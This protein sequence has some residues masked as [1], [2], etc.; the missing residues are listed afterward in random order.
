MGTAI[1]TLRHNEYY[2]LQKTFDKLYSL[3]KNGSKFKNL[4]PLL[5]SENNIMLAYRNI[6]SNSGSKTA[7]TDNKTIQDIEKLNKQILI[8]R[9]KNKLS[10]YKP[11]K[12]RRVYI[13]KKN[14]KLRP[15]GIPNIEDRIIQQCMKQ[16]LE[17]ISEAK[18][19]QHSYGFRPNRGTHNAMARCMHLVNQN[20]LTYVVDIDIKGFF[21]NVNHNI[22]IK[23]LWNMGIRDKRILCIIKKM[24]KAEIEG[25]G[26]PEKGT[27]QG[28]ILSPLLANIYLN[29]LDW[30]IASQWE[31]FPAKTQKEIK[32]QCNKNQ[33]YSN[34]SK[35]YRALRKSNLKEMFIVRYA[36]DFKIFCRNNKQAKKIYYGINKWL[37]EN[38]KLDISP[39]K[40]KIINLVERKS[41][42]LGFEMKAYE[43]KN[44][45]RG[46]YILRTYISNESLIKIKT[47]LFEYIKKIQKHPIQYQV[48]QLNAYIIGIH[49]YYE[50]AS[51]VYLD[52]NKI[53]IYY[54]KMIQRRLRNHISKEGF[55][56]QLYL[57]R[58]E[59]MKGYKVA[60]CN[61]QI[62]P[63]L[64]VKNKPPMNF[65]QKINNYT[66]EGRD[67]IHSKL[68]NINY[69]VLKFLREGNKFKS[70]EWND[71]RI[72]K[73]TS[74]SG[75]CAV[76]ETPLTINNLELHHI[77]PKE[78]GGEDKY[79]NC[80]L[81]TKDIHKLIHAVN[82]DIINKYIKITNIS[83]EEIKKIN[84]FR[85]KAGN[86]VILIG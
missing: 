34:K 52:L 33:P 63:L 9:I 17:P 78:I 16:I 45:M 25:E 22:L 54:R 31:E 51:N 43:K 65:N 5:I 56:S 61:I 57:S 32:G 75:I 77:I 84:K 12:V 81:I 27:P 8:D 39:E 73:Y 23:K 30:W 7:G 79:Q 60:I 49:E 82:F 62:Y 66:S 26:K 3:S 64:G 36:D 29:E 74:Q 10:N 53:N 69:E 28:G 48:V 1:K 20:Q 83:E 13:E 76:S 86:K 44:K 38:L 46:K 59:N 68:K 24:L 85:T 58:Y 55:K 19:Y 71:I 4:Y 70:V 47:K 40:S 67:L 41:N 11:T 18:F 6:K 37:K 21:D 80:I 14:G 42:Y 50:I 15:L 35:K 72:S 2:G